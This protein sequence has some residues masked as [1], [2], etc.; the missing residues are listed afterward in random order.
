MLRCVALLLH[1]VNSCFAPKIASSFQ[2]RG[3]DL[4]DFQDRPAQSDKNSRCIQTQKHSKT[5]LSLSSC[6]FFPFSLKNAHSY[7][8]AYGKH[9]GAN[10]Q[11]NANK[12]RFSRSCIAFCVFCVFAHVFI[13][14]QTHKPAYM[15][16]LSDRSGEC[17]LLG[18]TTPASSNSLPHIPAT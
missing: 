2:F 4:S 14:T 17:G 15:I 11:T 13:L 7:Q 1:C 9:N 6:S 16:H 3:S 5:C 12:Q 10:K 18:C 8:T